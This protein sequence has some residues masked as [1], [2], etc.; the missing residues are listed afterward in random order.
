MCC[1][2]GDHIPAPLLRLPLAHEDVPLI[3]TG[4]RV[5]VLV[6]RAEALV[7]D[8]GEGLVETEGI[9]QLHQFAVV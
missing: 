4:I 8:E 6:Q 5:A 2:P 1:L 9:A 3:L 7:P